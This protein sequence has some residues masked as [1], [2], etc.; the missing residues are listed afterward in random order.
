[1]KIQTAASGVNIVTLLLQGWKVSMKKKDRE[2]LAAALKKAQPLSRY[3][4]PAY[5]GWVDAVRAVADVLEKD[6]L[7][8]NRWEFLKACGVEDEEV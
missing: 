2:A 6:S 4:P 7:C 3:A 1:M 8:F 5:G